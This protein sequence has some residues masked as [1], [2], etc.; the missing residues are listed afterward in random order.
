M[1]IKGENL[2]RNSHIGKHGQQCCPLADK[3]G[4]PKGV[5][6][7][8]KDVETGKMTDAVNVCQL[9]PFVAPVIPGLPVAPPQKL[10]RG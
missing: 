10:A 9:T 8:L 6:Y 1:Q 7:P 4:E 5:A 2:E 3:A